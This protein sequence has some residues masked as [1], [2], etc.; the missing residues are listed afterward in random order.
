[1]WRKSITFRLA[2]YFGGASTAVLLAIGYLVGL[3]VERHFLELDHADLH[4]KMELVRHVLSKVQTPADVEA[5]PERM[6]DALIGHDR[7]V[8]ERHPA[9]RQDAVRYRWRG[10]PRGADRWRRQGA[11][12]ADVRACLMGTRRSG[13]PRLREPG[14]DAPRR[15]AARLSWP[16]PSISPCT[17]RSW[18]ASTRYSGWRSPPGSS[19]PRCSA[20]SPQG[21]AWHPSAR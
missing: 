12:G 6:G 11:R 21:E 15:A 10:L 5:L 4:G 20:G 16:L 1:M 7:V 13:L 2:L 19:A 18:R 14:P 17:T 8:G 9:P 3:S